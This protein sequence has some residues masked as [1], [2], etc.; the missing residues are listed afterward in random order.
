M[1]ESSPAHKHYA[2]AQTRLLEP[3]LSNYLHCELQYFGPDLSALLAKKIIEIFEAVCP[4]S[5][6]VKPGQMVWNALH[7]HTRGDYK[8]RKL[9]PVILTLINDED[10]ESLRKGDSAAKVRQKAMARVFEEAYAQGGILSTRDAGLLFHIHYS[11]ATAIRIDYEKKQ[12][13]HLP[14]PGV[15]HDMGST[16]SHK[17]II[18]RKVIMEKKDPTTVARETKHSQGAVD[19]YLK[20]FH[21]INTIYRI[22]PDLAFIHQVTGFSKTLIKEYVNIIEEWADEK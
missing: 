16:I 4:S 3:L 13:Q 1:I 9:V 6:H 15:L 10:I 11:T 7:K 12:G 22:M 2:S 20:D 18:V 5:E 17:A 19:R 8:N 14:H 21:R